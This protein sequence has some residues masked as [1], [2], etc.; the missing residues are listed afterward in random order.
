MLSTF[1]LSLH[2]VRM[3]WTPYLAGTGVL[4]FAGMSFFFALAETALFSLSRWQARQ[5]AAR[6]PNTGELLARLLAEP[7]HLLATIV[8]GNTLANAFIVAITLWSAPWGDWRYLLILPALF[9]IIL[10]GCEVAPKTLAVRAPES[11]ALRV[12]RP[13]R[14]LQNFTHL[15]RA[16]AQRLDTFI[17]QTLVPRSVQ[18][19]PV[20]SDEEYQEL[21]ELAYQQGT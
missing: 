2:N 9:F 16:A 7:H 17:L 8:L 6:A 19:Q 5:L 20:M 4:V 12:A 11:W 18:P 13:M 1:R 21:L 10:I 14:A 3:A 15:V